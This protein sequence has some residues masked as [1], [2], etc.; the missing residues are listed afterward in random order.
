MSEESVNFHLFIMPTIIS[1][2]SRYYVNDTQSSLFSFLSYD[3]NIN[4][5][6][7]IIDLHRQRKKF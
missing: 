4:E 2:Q 6:F 3:K 1:R 7:N 5:T